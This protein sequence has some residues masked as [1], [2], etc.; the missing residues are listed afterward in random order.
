MNY[1]FASIF[2]PF[3]TSI[4]ALLATI[5]STATLGGNIVVLIAFFIE[6]SLRIPSNYFIASLAMTD[7]LIGLFSMN[8]FI[9]YQLLGYWPLGHL[10]CDLWL[11]LDFSACLTSQYTVFL[12]TLDRF[13]LVK[14]P[15]KYRNWRTYNKVRIMI[16]I[17]WIFPATLFTLLIFGWSYIT[18]EKQRELTKCD[19][20]F[21]YYPIFNTTL[22]VGYFWITL[23]I[24]CSLYVG[25]Y[26]VA[27]RL[28]K[29]SLESSKRLV[30]FLTKID[31]DSIHSQSNQDSI[32]DGDNH[33]HDNNRTIPGRHSKSKF[34]QDNIQ[35]RRERT[36]KHYCY[37]TRS[38][39]NKSLE[40][41]NLTSNR[42]SK[43]NQTQQNS[44]TVTSENQRNS[45]SN[46]PI[47]KCHLEYGSETSGC[48]TFYPTNNNSTESKTQ[49][50]SIIEKSQLL[51]NT[52][53]SKKYEDSNIKISK[54]E[55]LSSISDENFSLPSVNFYVPS[56]KVPISSPIQNSQSTSSKYIESDDSSPVWI[57]KDAC[58][59]SG[60]NLYVYDICPQLMK[61]HTLIHEG[62]NICQNAICLSDSTSWNQCIQSCCLLEKCEYSDYTTS[63]DN[64]S[65]TY[66]NQST[67]NDYWCLRFM[68]K[69]NKSKQ[70]QTMKS[71]CIYDP[72]MKHNSV[73]WYKSHDKSYLT[74]LP[75]KSNINPNREICPLCQINK[76]NN[77]N[78]VRQSKSKQNPSLH[79]IIKQIKLR[80]QHCCCCCCILPLKHINISLN[81]NNNNNPTQY[82]SSST[83]NSKIIRSNDNSDNDYIITEYNQFKTK[84]NK[85]SLKD[86]YKQQNQ[87]SEYQ[88]SIINKRQTTFSIFQSLSNIDMQNRKHA[89]KALKTIS[90]ILGAFIFCWTPYHIIVLIKGFCDDINTYTSCVNIHLYNLSYWLCYMNS[91]IN[92]FCYALSNISFRRTFF[93]I[94]KCDFQ[95]R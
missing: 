29:K 27:H 1:T 70:N 24:M 40:N 54:D 75:S 50:S 83:T 26:K 28:Q 19:V 16:C 57:K 87:Q 20:S 14:I 15:A 38:S 74:E 88:K 53:I 71:S 10:I 94:L 5:I 73:L 44:L 23:I 95:K 41:F 9:T 47:N 49:L 62:G 30:Q 51:S 81:N 90:L 33:D 82:Q 13:C 77:D 72:S 58:Y 78:I 48:S 11:S 31:Q 6:R 64:P 56:P 55:S 65:S 67:M 7:V 68:D 8:L 86:K 66:Y 84:H 36:N 59:D 39:Y 32:D 3:T 25:I 42:K 46:Y 61:C 37:E 21:T 89:C 17:S 85:L 12:I 92:P 52:D 34:V 76:D 22:T 93:R 60:L 2:P 69:W 63:T 79:R 43:Y 18:G 80:V 4:I 91:P 35:Q 45:K